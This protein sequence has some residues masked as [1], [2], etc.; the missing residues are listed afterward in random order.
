MPDRTR[1]HLCLAILLLAAAGPSSA[2]ERCEMRE[3]GRD[4][5]RLADGSAVYV[6]PRVF[7]T[8]G[9]VTLLAG[10]WT[11]VFGPG[12][13]G[14]YP[15][16]P[17]RTIAGVLLRSGRAPELLPWPRPGFHHLL[18]ATPRPAG[19]FLVGAVELSDTSF[20]PS[21][22]V[23]RN[24]WVG[25]WDGRWLSVDVLPRT[26]ETLV[27]VHASAPVPTTSGWAWAFPIAFGE[28]PWAFA[29][30]ER[31]AGIWTV[32][33]VP[34]S[35]PLAYV[36]PLPVTGDLAAAVV[37]QDMRTGGRLNSIALYRRSFLQW[38]PAGFLNDEGGVH[39]VKN[40]TSLGVPVLSWLDE[41][42]T[43]RT[44][45]DV[46]N[47]GPTRIVDRSV[48]DHALAAAGGSTYWVT[49]HAVADTARTIRIHDLTDGRLRLLAEVPSPYGGF[50]GATALAP[51]VVQVVGPLVSRDPREVQAVSLILQF[52][53]R[54]HER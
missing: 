36:E 37:Q 33:V 25:E 34:T 43:V 21:P 48:S 11:Y 29:L 51:D 50:L 12:E 52:E 35:G 46:Q 45:V 27:P 13:T 53:L 7:V 16:A 6:E 3:T 54:C 30:F 26:P 41:T 8:S 24:V 2:Q 17:E 20:E 40:G 32:D 44:I 9:D 10:T 38:R 47:A 18:R 31:L 14:V 1:I 19:G 39:F 49:H 22:D 15:K 5:L 28:R 4:T 42:A 23:V